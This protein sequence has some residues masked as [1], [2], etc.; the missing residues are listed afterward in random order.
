MHKVAIAVIHF[1]WWRVVPW[2]ACACRRNVVAILLGSCLLC[3]PPIGIKDYFETTVYRL[4]C[5]LVWLYDVCCSK[6]SHV[7]LT[8]WAVRELDGAIICHVIHNVCSCTHTAQVVL[9]SGVVQEL[10][11]A[12]KLSRSQPPA[13]S[14]QEVRP[15][16]EL[17]TNT[18]LGRVTIVYV[19]V[20]SMTRPE[21]GC[22]M[23][24]IIWKWL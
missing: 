18:V 10:D 23:F 1:F 12:A 16:L 5:M 4:P 22:L 19:V 3:F 21:N 14:V 2:C 9:T 17:K 6:K 13:G 7:V 20:I 15:F 11:G 8:S 24:A